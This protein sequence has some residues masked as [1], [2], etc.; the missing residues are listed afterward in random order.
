[1]IIYTRV[2]IDMGTVLPSNGAAPSHVTSLP[3]ESHG[4]FTQSLRSCSFMGTTAQ[5]TEGVEGPRMVGA[6]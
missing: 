6:D 1:M 3:T 5:F 2:E 4:T